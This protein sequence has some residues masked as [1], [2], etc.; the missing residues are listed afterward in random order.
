MVGIYKMLFCFLVIVNEPEAIVSVSVLFFVT[1]VTR[2]CCFVLDDVVPS[3]IM[4]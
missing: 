3:A 4:L 2:D 1:E